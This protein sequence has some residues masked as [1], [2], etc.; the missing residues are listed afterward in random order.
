MAL[1][2]LLQAKTVDSHIW[3]MHQEGPKMKTIKRCHHH[4]T[5]SHNHHQQNLWTK[6]TMG[7]TW[8]GVRWGLIY[9]HSQISTKLAMFFRPRYSFLTNRLG[10]DWTVLSHI[11]C[12]E[13]YIIA[14]S[15][16]NTFCTPAP[17]FSS[18]QPQNWKHSQGGNIYWCIA[19]WVPCKKSC[20][21]PHNA[22]W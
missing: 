5:P 3:L 11:Q 6:G 18:N 12:S 7:E 22:K 9:A 13:D 2:A 21:Q 15:I 20:E 8:N 10:Q 17:M 16:F 1:N 4:R 14:S 19:L